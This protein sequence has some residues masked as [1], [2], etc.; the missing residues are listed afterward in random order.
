MR[1]SARTQVP[2]GPR[3][4][5][6]LH[7]NVDFGGIETLQVQ[8]LR[9]LDHDRYEG[10]VIVARYASSTS[11]QFRDQLADIDVPMLAARDVTKRS[12]WSVL[13]TAWS[14]RQLLRRERVDVAHVQTRTPHSSWLLTMGA[15][16]ARVPAIIRTEHVSP[17][18]HLRRFSR[19]TVGV[20]DWTTDLVITDSKAD[21]QEQIDLLRRRP[22]KVIASYCGIDPYQF[23]PEHDVAAA[24]R[25]IGLDPQTPVVGSVGRL[26]EQK[27][28]RYLIEAARRVI[29]Q[30]DGPVTFL[31]VGGGEEEGA[32]RAL[33]AAGDITDHVRFVGFQPDAVPY[34][35]AMDVVVMPSLW[36][37]FSISMQEFMALGKA[38]V[39]SDHHSFQE[40]MVDGEHGLIVPRRD[41]VGLAD[42]ILKLLADDVQRRE[43]GR[44]ALARARKDFSIQ[45]HVDE[46]MD[47]YDGVLDARSARWWKRRR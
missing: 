39:V 12:V 27:G 17:G 33:A 23:D 31:L 30:H 11:T 16:L 18:P 6:F 44:A 41:S 45:R 3:R 9:N 46:L 36:E 38:M 28:H 35:E 10:V 13:R 29:E 32:L 4:V 15:Y 5:A 25:A 7:D 40:A 22:S 37:G 1:R 21:R 24:K 47:L 8:E 26:H 42:A 19:H 34:M 20:L 2:R 43:L 14:M